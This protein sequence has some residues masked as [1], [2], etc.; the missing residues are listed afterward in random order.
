MQIHGPHGDKYSADGAADRW[1]EARRSTRKIVGEGGMPWLVWKWQWTLRE[2]TKPHVAQ[3]Q[4]TPATAEV[5]HDVGTRKPKRQDDSCTRCGL[6]HGDTGKCPAHGHKCGKCGR[7]KHWARFCKTKR[8][9]RSGTLHRQRGR[10]TSSSRPSGDRK[11]RVDEITDDLETLV[12][13]TVSLDSINDD[14]KERTQAF[15]RL[16]LSI[17]LI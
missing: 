15:V 17:V 12:F 5:V 13:Q 2:P 11:T 8:S 3:L 9:G 4:A 14:Q 10:S 16:S 1:H 7:P 6:N